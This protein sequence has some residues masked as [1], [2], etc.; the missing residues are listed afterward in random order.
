MNVNL[1]P[2]MLVVV[3]A[4]F[5][6]F[7]VPAQAQ[8]DAHHAMLGRLAECRT[9][10]IDA[11]AHLGMMA[12]ATRAHPSDAAEHRHMLDRLAHCR[13]TMTAAIAHMEDMARMHH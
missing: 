10:Q 4:S 11:I 7:S 3:A 5:A 2:A 6:A 12:R 9:T 1:K 13:D 8:P